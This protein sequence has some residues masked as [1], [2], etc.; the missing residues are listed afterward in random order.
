[1]SPSVDRTAKMA[2]RRTMDARKP[3]LRIIEAILSPRAYA[4]LS[5]PVQRLL[6]GP[7]SPIFPTAG[8]QEVGKSGRPKSGRLAAQIGKGALDLQLGLRTNK[9]QVETR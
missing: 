9:R 5:N 6:A 8:K 4:A 2:I 3:R 1:M 7:P